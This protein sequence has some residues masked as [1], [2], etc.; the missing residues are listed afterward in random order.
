[1][2][3]SDLPHSVQW[4]SEFVTIG[5]SIS[6]Y[7]LGA[8][9]WDYLGGIFYRGA[10]RIHDGKSFF[11]NETEVAAYG[12]HYRNLN[13]KMTS[14]QQQ[15]AA[16]IANLLGIAESTLAPALESLQSTD[17]SKGGMNR[18]AG[19]IANFAIKTRKFFPDIS[20]DDPDLGRTV[21]MV[22]T[23]YLGDRPTRLKLYELTIQQIQNYDEAFAE[24]ESTAAMYRH[25]IR[26]WAGLSADG[27][28]ARCR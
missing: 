21:N 6:L 26:L 22:F 23:N 4:I 13:E 10:F 8:P 27:R 20:V 25:A 7:K 16:R 3:K 12:R 18:A 9:F 19:R 15:G 14:L 28:G 17:P 11:R 24:D 2:I 5:T 1:M